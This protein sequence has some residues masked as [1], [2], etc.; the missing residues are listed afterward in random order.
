MNQATSSQ[1]PQIRREASDGILTLTF[2]RDDKLNAVS[3]EM[4]DVIRSAVSDFAEHD[5]HRVLVLAAEGRFYTAGIDIG[6]IDEAASTKS[7][8]GITLRRQYRRL[9]VLFDEI[10]SI[11]KPVIHAAQGPCFGIG[12]EL[13]ASSIRPI[14]MPAV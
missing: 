9:H 11:E 14:S 10:E 3:P 7:R 1:H 4:L 8:S 12:V 2:T 5:E 6:R 13:A